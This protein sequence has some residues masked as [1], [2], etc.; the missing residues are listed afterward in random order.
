MI[1]TIRELIHE[2]SRTYYANWHYISNNIVQPSTGILNTYFSFY[3]VAIK[4]NYSGTNYV[5]LYNI[6]EVLLSPPNSGANPYV[7][8]FNNSIKVHPPPPVTFN[9]KFVLDTQT[10]TIVTGTQSGATNLGVS[11]VQPIDNIHVIYSND[12]DPSPTDYTT[13][14]SIANHV[15]QRIFAIQATDFYDLTYTENKEPPLCAFRY[16]SL[17]DY[18]FSHIAV[19]MAYLVNGEL[20]KYCDG[21]IVE[22]SFDINY[23]FQSDLE[24][25]IPQYGVLYI[26]IDEMINIFIKQNNNSFNV[27]DVSHSISSQLVDNVYEVVFQIAADEQH[28]PYKGESTN[29]TED[30]FVI[31]HDFISSYNSQIWWDGYYP[32]LFKGSW[33]KNNDIIDRQTIHMWGNNSI[34]TIQAQMYYTSSP[35]LTIKKIRLPNNTFIQTPVFLHPLIFKQSTKNV[36]QRYI[37]RNEHCFIKNELLIDKIIFLILMPRIDLC[38]DAQVEPKLE[39]DVR[40]EKILMLSYEHDLPTIYDKMQQRQW[41]Y[42][43][44][45][46]AGYDTSQTL[47]STGGP[48]QPPIP[49][50]PLFEQQ[51]E[52]II[53]EN[54]F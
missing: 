15:A 54:I 44:V 46:K 43:G 1:N 23:N 3:N 2:L 41:D 5:P 33:I 29:F 20:K 48:Q 50:M 52:N 27:S 40:Y 25:N 35:Y 28:I 38:Y 32:L 13:N 12:L 53:L 18:S 45:D 17:L 39:G 24:N 21:F 26:D 7:N 10:N 19:P 37:D 36:N 34:D 4:D 42:T 14:I 22:Y 51:M 16:I 49:S 8:L 11:Y 47:P 6:Y 31:Y 30:I 9:N